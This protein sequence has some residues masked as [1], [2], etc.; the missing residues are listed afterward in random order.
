MTELC[1]GGSLNDF[2]RSAGTLRLSVLKKVLR[3]TLE[4]LSVLHAHGAIHR[5]L[6][7][8]NVYVQKATGDVRVGDYGLAAFSD[9]AADTG[10]ATSRQNDS[11][12][13]M[14][15]GPRRYSYRIQTEMQSTTKKWT[16]GALE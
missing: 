14:F 7:A 3:Q 11:G 2:L 9:E 13:S 10:K 8:E 15:H 16:F 5:D 6:K 4:G 1:S 12:H